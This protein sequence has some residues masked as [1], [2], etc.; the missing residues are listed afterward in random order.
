MWKCCLSC[1]SFEKKINFYRGGIYLPQNSLETYLLK[2]RKIKKSITIFQNLI[3]ID[4]NLVLISAHD[5]NF[6]EN[7]FTKKILKKLAKS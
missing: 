5:R 3:T 4:N 6:F 2:T 7:F 1:T